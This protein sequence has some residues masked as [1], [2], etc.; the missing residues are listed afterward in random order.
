[1]F[2][3]YNWYTVIF[4]K[5][6]TVKIADE[7]YTYEDF[8]QKMKE[9]ISRRVEE[10]YVVYD[11]EKD[12]F[13]VKY[14][15]CASKGDNYRVYYGKDIITKDSERKDIVELLNKLIS[16]TEKTKADKERKKEEEKLEEDRCELAIKNGNKGIFRSDEDKSRYLEYLK[17]ELKKTKFPFNRLG[18][19]ILLLVLISVITAGIVVFIIQ[20]IIPN[21][22]LG[23]MV[24]F[25]F[26]ILCL[27]SMDED[28]KNVPTIFQTLKKKHELKKKIKSLAKAL[29]KNIH[30]TKALVEEAK[31]N[32]LE[33]EKDNEKK[34]NPVI[35]DILADFEKLTQKIEEIN[36]IEEKKKYSKEILEMLNYFKNEA[37]KMAT[38][39]DTLDFRRNI[40]NQIVSLTGRIEETIKQ[41]VELAKTK[42]E[43]EEMLEEVNRVGAMSRGK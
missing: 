12:C 22:I 1:M 16:I 18:Y 42:T 20:G 32:G 34:T 28:L 31:E 35:D 9:K 6:G 21:V 15:R 38:T 3:N 25:F 7:E 40:T 24:G 36:S 19:Y 4:T 43:F 29:T 26:T 39:G 23:L 33:E 10:N 17:K 13:I 37:K 27:T 5:L 2:G 11:E 30:K 41:E 8:F 14:H